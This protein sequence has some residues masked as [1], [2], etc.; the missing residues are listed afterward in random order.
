MGGGG[1]RPPNVPTKKNHVHVTYTRERAKRASTSETYIF[2]GLKIHL[3]TYIQ[4]TA[5]PFITYWG[6]T[7]KTLTLRKIYGYASELR[8]CSHFHTLKRQ[9]PSICCWYFR[10]TLSRKYIFSGLK[11]H[12]HTLYNQCSFLLLLKVWR[13]IY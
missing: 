4:S 13:Y 7:D 3:H 8:K 11:L 2:S 9:F 12:L 1:A 6:Y 10:Y 5:V